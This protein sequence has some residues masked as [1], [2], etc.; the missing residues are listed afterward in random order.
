MAQI[1]R[2]EVIQRMHNA[3]IVAM[4]RTST[5]TGAL[6]A[7]QALTKAGVRV[8]EIACIVPDLDL[9]SVCHAREA[10]CIPAGLTPTK[11]LTTLNAGADPVKLFPTEAV[12]GPRSIADVLTPLPD[13]RLMAF[14][15]VEP[16]HVRAY[17]AAG[18]RCVGLGSALMP[19]QHIA[20][21][22]MSGL[23]AHAHRC[24]GMVEA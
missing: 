22:D 18:C 19:K 9:I 5:T 6:L 13:L 12:G 21:G 4:F 2:T 1:S 10:A 15:R 14:D 20:K 11:L 17:L 7:G 16:E 24:L 8:L 23:T 3:R